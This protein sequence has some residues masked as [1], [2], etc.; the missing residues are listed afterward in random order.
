M[1]EIDEAYPQANKVLL[2]PSR[3]G[4]R[5]D[6]RTRLRE[7]RVRTQTPIEFFDVGFSWESGRGAATAASALAA[8]GREQ[9]SRLVAQ[10]FVERTT[11]VEGADLLLHLTRALNEP[12]QGAAISIVVGPAGIGKSAFFQSLFAALLDEFRLQKARRRVTARPVPLLPQYL[13]I[14]SAR[15]VKSLLEAFLRTDFVRSVGLPVFEW[16]LLNGYALWMLDGLDEVIGLDP[17]FLEYIEDLV[18]RPGAAQGPRILLCVRDSLLASDE[19]LREI[20]AF[21]PGVEIIEL[22]RWS[23]PSI[24]RFAELRLGN[25]SDDFLRQLLGSSGMTDLASLPFYEELLAELYDEGS[26]RSDYSEQ[27]LIDHAVAA[28]IEREYRKNTISRELV[29]ERAIREYAGALAMEEFESA[30]AGVAIEQAREF[31]DVVAVDAAITDQEVERLA[32]NLTQLPFFAQ[33]STAAIRFAQELV[34]EYFLGEELIRLLEGDVYLLRKRL[35]AAPL[36]A[37]S[38]AMR[39]LAAHVR[40]TNRVHR[41]VDL[42]QHAT[43]GST[44]FSNMLQLEMAADGGARSLKGGPPLEYADLSGLTFVDADLSGISFRGANLT[45]VA[46]N[47]CDLSGADLE[48]A[49]LLGTAFDAS[50]AECM[51]GMSVGS[52]QRFYSMRVADGVLDDRAAVARWFDAKT[53]T[54]SGSEILCSA[55]QQL[56]HLFGKYVRPDGNPRRDML[57]ENGLLRGAQFIAHPRDVLDAAVRYGYLARVGP[58][59]QYR[60]AGGEQYR[61]MVEFVRDLELTPGIRTL[62]ADVCE[63]EAC[64]HVHSRSPIVRR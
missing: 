55:A 45:D 26:L 24:D 1:D 40:S 57:K 21:G 61:E 22:Q 14:A 6:L 7:L 37:S 27:D 20:Q 25:R 58:H 51:K 63:Q 46:F 8:S 36:S 3:D 44:E 34:E 50:T 43:P 12:A 10:P 64:V 62:L 52:L 31:A 11:G 28:L 41:I 47:R 38:L 5:A 32:T 19:G 17:T 16:M 30:H 39:M 18:T 2:V 13:D 49:I 23:Q 42:V 33:G 9:R 59:Q 4:L 53:G 48:E 29:S 54:S 15:T 35:R 60:R 56:R